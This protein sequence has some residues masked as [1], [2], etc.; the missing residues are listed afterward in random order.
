MKKLNL[1]A[2][3]LCMAALFSCGKDDSEPTPNPDIPGGGSQTEM[4][5]IG[6]IWEESAEYR[7]ESTDGGNSWH[8]VNTTDYDKYKKEAWVWD[9]DRLSSVTICE[10]PGY[11]SFTCDFMYNENGKISKLIEGGEK[12]EVKYDGNRISRIDLFYDGESDGYLYVTYSNDK[13]TKMEGKADY[14]GDQENILMEFVW[15]GDNLT[16]FVLSEDGDVD[17]ISRFQSYDNGNNPHY[18]QDYTL[19]NLLC[20]GLEDRTFILSANNCTS[21]DFD[22]G[23]ITYEYSYNS[24]NYPTKAIRT[25]TGLPYNYGGVMHRTKRVTT[26]TYEY[27]E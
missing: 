12:Y 20:W 10:G 9:G 7:E 2:L 21:V 5:K 1:L 17:W 14:K 3:G 6:A 16:K 11:G 15:S 26:Y 27:V 24:K 19:L 8:V 4:V 22:E 25:H 18:R 13:I 23:P